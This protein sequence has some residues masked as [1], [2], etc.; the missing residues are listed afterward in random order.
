MLRCAK[1]A[2]CQCIEWPVALFS[3]DMSQ[4]F[5]DLGEKWILSNSER[6]RYRLTLRDSSPYPEPLAAK[7]PCG[8]GLLRPEQLRISAEHRSLSCINISLR[9]V[10]L[11]ALSH[12]SAETEGQGNLEHS[13]AHS[14]S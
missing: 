13:H 4:L 5:K 10:I 14:A 7:L 8:I 9:L 3:T 1:Y 11:Q 2:Q 12:V 6:A